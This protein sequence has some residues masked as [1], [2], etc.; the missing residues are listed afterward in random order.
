MPIEIVHTGERIPLEELLASHRD[1]LVLDYLSQLRT[2]G[3]AEKTLRTKRTIVAA[4][5]RWARNRRVPCIELSTTDLEAF[6]EG[7][8]PGH[9]SRWRYARGILLGL[10]AFLHLNG[11]RPGPLEPLDD[12]C[13]TGLLARYQDFL[14]NERG[15]TK[16][17]VYVY[18][19]LVRT[20][21]VGLSRHSGSQRPCEWNA[22]A[23]HAFLL[24]RSHNRSCEG[25]RLVAVTLRS[26][27]RF[28]YLR[29]EVA[30]DLSLGV[31]RFQKWKLATVPTYL[32]P[33]EVEKVLAAC[34]V[35]TPTGRR[36][37]AILLLL[38]RLGLRA[39]EVVTLE[40]GDIAWRAGEIL[41]RGKGQ[42][43]DHLPLPPDVGE[44]IALYLRQD[45]G[46]SASP[47]AFLRLKAPRE[48]LTGPAAVGHIVRKL[49]ARVGII[50]T[51]RGAAHMF[52]H[53]LATRMIRHGASISEIAEVLRH[54]SQNTTG[55]YAK[56]AFQTL[57]EVA[58]PWPGEGGRQ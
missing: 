43:R 35:A 22:E 53:S 28:L 51:S 32:S 50:R 48:G 14:I 33:A 27:L 39:G 54:R 20:A 19:P 36:D 55:L 3:F 29:G 1:P 30:F 46:E 21:I 57:R 4:F 10:L 41:V 15:L 47:R 49:L 9:N 44:A 18:T 5:L 42:Q 34:D 31:S 37:R 26:L 17:T 45:R 40:V 8:R 6:L 23:V 13:R 16:Q 11:A 25:V 58:R 38:A 56:V 2:A 7:C 52:R 12:S 24:E